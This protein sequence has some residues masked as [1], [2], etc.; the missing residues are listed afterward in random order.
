MPGRGAG[1]RARG[2]VR[3]VGIG[4]SGQ[5]WSQ[6]RADVGGELWE[7]W[8]WPMALIISRPLPLIHPQSPPPAT[9]LSYAS[10]KEP[11]P[12]QAP[13]RGPCPFQTGVRW[14]HQPVRCLCFLPG[15]LGHL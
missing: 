13:S 5:V 10:Y 4:G 7:P 14:Q 6:P 2:H 15:A 12:G 8:P 1:K 3:E 9:G 11:I